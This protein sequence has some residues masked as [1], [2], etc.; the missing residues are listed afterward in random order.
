LLVIGVTLLFH[1]QYGTP[2]AVAESMR[3]HHY[4]GASVILV[5]LFRTADILWQHK[6]WLAYPWIIF[7][8]ITAALLITYREPY[9]AYRTVPPAIES[10]Q[11]YTVAHA[12]L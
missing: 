4:Q 9:G 2:E 8:F 10:S 12:D 7:L 6:K 1:T 3:K 11:I 5:A